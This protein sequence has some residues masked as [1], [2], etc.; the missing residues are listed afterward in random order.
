MKLISVPTFV[1][2]AALPL[3]PVFYCLRGVSRSVVRVPLNEAVPEFIFR[4]FCVDQERRYQLIERKR[5]R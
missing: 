1:F 4:C 5:T 3:T 2:L